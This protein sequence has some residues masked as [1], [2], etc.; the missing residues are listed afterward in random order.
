MKLS[1][2]DLSSIVAVGH[3]DGYLGL[4]IDRGEEIEYIEI[5]APNA[6]YQGLQQVNSLAASESVALPP[7][8]KQL[9]MQPV[10]SSM[11]KAVGYDR[12]NQTLQVEFNSG[13]VY[14][15]ASV[16]QETWES[17]QTADSTGRFF[18]RQIKGKYE[19]D[20]VDDEIETTAIEVDYSYD[21]YLEEDE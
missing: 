20:R 5:P 9:V 4:L 15:Y 2:I 19:C 11:A 8:R 14:Q 18:N 6:A 10:N 17:L 12:T 1:K 7:D 13:S 21:C 3:S 16:E